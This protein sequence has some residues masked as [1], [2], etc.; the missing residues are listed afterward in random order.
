MRR[1]VI[2]LLLLAASAPGARAGDPLPIIDACLS[3]I[4]VGTD[5]GYARIAQL[6][7]ELPNELTQSRAA[8]WLPADW[9]R[10]DN[11]LSAQ[12]LAELRIL[13]LQQQTPA[14]SRRAPP[15]VD[16]VAAVLAQV[17]H[18]EQQRPAGWWKRLKDWLRRLF[19]PQPK[20]GESWVKRWLDTVELSDGVAAVIAWSALTVTVAF[21]LALLLHELRLAGLFAERERSLRVAGSAGTAMRRGA[22]LAEIRS[23]APQEQP[24]LLLALIANRLAEQDRLPPARAFTS[25]ELVSRALLPDESLRAPLADLAAVSD[26]VRFSDQLVAAE[27]L[28]AA[29]AGGQSVL[30]TIEPSRDARSEGA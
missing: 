20:A 30:A 19:T 15:R 3:K 4:D 16:S 8:V 9:N 13:L 29:V 26:S 11:Q 27:R 21:A 1:W 14:T 24:G 25:R 17:L 18:G 12:G 2:A 5:V 28:A 10:A 7:P 22:S 23:A 6:C